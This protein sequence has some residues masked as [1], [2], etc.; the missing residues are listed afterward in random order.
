ME[1]QLNNMN[2]LSRLLLLLCLVIFF[3]PANAE[4]YKLGAVNIIRIG[5]QSPQAEKAR[6]TLEKEF[7]SRDKQFTATQKEV[8]A[9]EDK[10]NKDSAIMSEDERSK[11]ERDILNKKRDLKRDLDE[12]REDLN[13]RR[14]EE[15][16]KIQK[17]IVDAIQK[18]AK[19]NNFDMILTDGVLYASP[20]VDVTNLVIDYMK[21][22]GAV[23]STD[24]KSES[25]TES[26]PDSK[27]DR[28]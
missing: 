21:K 25:K 17:E 2:M 12:Y 13:L 5:E 18:V 28:K 16:A 11:L 24:S 7:S 19:D 9:Q 27:T 20:K 3:A 4:D 15:F 26:K 10:L 8:K 22:Q 6:T 1:L 14:N 23:T